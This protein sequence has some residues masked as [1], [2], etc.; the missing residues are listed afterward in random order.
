VRAASGDPELAAS[1]E[2]DAQRKAIVHYLFGLRSARGISQAEMAKRLDCSQSRI[3]KLENSEDDDLRLGDLRQYLRVLDHELM[4][5]IGKR[6]WTLVEQVKFFALSIESCLRSMVGL[7]EKD[8]RIRD[9]VSQIHVETFDN[10][11]K[12]IL[13]SAQNVPQSPQPVPTL[14][15]ADD[16][17]EP[18]D[19][20][21]SDKPQRSGE[22]LT[23]YAGT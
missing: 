6:H 16:Y 14:I 18:G 15:H 1:V 11:V 21:R 19:G 7:A 22:R 17:D 4:L 23:R 8:T 5:V 20:A 12:I 9:G 13:Q 3:S 10:L 2:A